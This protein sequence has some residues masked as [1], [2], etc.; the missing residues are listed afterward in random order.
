MCSSLKP[1]RWS[2]SSPILYLHTAHSQRC[3]TVRLVCKDGTGRKVR[4]GERG[5]GVRDSQACDMAKIPKAYDYVIVGAGSAGCTLTN[6]LTEDHERPRSRAGGWAAGTG[7][8]FLKLSAWL[9]Q[10]AGRAHL[11]TGAMTVSRRRT[12]A[13]RRIESGRAARSWGGSSS[14]QCHG[15]CAR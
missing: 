12:M 9:G 8:P 4:R 10:G 15:I 6:R 7:N 14:I 13:G 1:E 5:G 3:Q 2:C 11:W